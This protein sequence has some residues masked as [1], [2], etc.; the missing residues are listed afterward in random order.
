MP[1]IKLY[2]PSA[3]LLLVLTCAQVSR[4]VPVMSKGQLT[5]SCVTHA[6]MLL[7]NVT[8]ALTQ[9]TLFSAIDCPEQSVELHMETNT[10]FV[11]APKGST[12]SG[13]ATSEFD[14]DACLTNIGEDLHHYYT[15]LAAQPDPDRLLA[16]TVLSL[17]ELMENCF[18]WS[19]PT[20]LEAAADRLSTYDERLRLC[21]VLK[22]FQLRSITINR[23]I[24]Y[25]ASGDH[26][27]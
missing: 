24:A 1:L 27:I 9:K 12:C 26:A 20:D 4:S 15:F 11:C 25:M 16:P 17:R 14:Q 8:H 10:P 21:K 18:T 19:L 5:D 7:E 22:G 6:Q 3:L 23:G 13:I 2:I